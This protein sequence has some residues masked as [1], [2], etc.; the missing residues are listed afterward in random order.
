LNANSCCGTVP[1]ALSSSLATDQN[2]VFKE[3]SITKDFHN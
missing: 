1:L 2:G 3:L